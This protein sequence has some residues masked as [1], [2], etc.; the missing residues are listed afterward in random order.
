MVH[1]QPRKND[2]NRGLK[3]YALTARKQAYSTI[4]GLFP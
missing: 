2:L 3:D 4:I 1:S